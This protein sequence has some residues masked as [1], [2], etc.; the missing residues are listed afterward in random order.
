MLSFTE[1]IRQYDLSLKKVLGGD[2]VRL[3]RGLRLD[4]SVSFLQTVVT[5]SMNRIISLESFMAKAAH[6]LKT[7]V[8]HVGTIRRMMHQGSCEFVDI[9]ILI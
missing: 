9:T 3:R 4:I 7:A 5:Q 6:V 8:R 1:A 2:P